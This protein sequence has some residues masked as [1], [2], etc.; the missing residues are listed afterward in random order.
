MEFSKDRLILFKKYFNNYIVKKP[1]KWLIIMIIYNETIVLAN[2][3][4]WRVWT[5]DSYRILQPKGK[6]RDII[7]LDFYFL[8]SYLNLVFFLYKK[9]KKLVELSI[10]FEAITYF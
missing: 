8:W 4:Y 5:L 10:P 6:K 9:Q 1:N 3:R 7:V 2:N